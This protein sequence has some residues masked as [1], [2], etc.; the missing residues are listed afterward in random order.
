MRASA[1]MNSPQRRSPG[2]VV[3]RARASVFGGLSVA[4]T[5]LLTGCQPAVSERLQ[6]Y[7]EGEY[8]YVACPL[9]GAVERL[10]VERGDQVKAG[11]P[12]F[13]L[14][15][16]LERAARDEAERRSIQGLAALEDATKGK[17]P[18]EMDALAASLKQAQAALELAE[19]ELARQQTLWQ[20]GASAQQEMDAAHS[21]RDQCR[22]RVRSLE[23]ELE[24]ARLG[25]RAD[26][27]AAAEANVR[28]LEAALTQ[29]EWSLNQ[30]RQCAPE[31]GLVFDTLFREGEWVAAGRPVVVLL[32]PA[33]I[34]LRVFVP[35]A[36]LA[37]LQLGDVVQVFMDGV[38]DSVPATVNFISPRA[39]YSPP[40]VYSRANRE[41]FVYLIEAVFEGG[42]AARLHPGQ[43]VEVVLPVRRP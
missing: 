14:D 6:G 38:R 34:K 5:M 30:K 21:T 12:L 42:I 37:R 1:M 23:A 15:S 27:V 25:A 9:G 36:Q 17:R 10:Y 7:L 22:E 28:A 16:S 8:V 24:T 31:S 3:G 19:K 20:A 4:V 33:N 32:P 11:D 35:E 26:Q 2:C 40:M 13:A 41:K 39:E 29:A 18:S 43:P